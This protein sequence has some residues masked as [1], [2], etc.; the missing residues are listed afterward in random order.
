M[1]ARVRFLTGNRTGITALAALAGVL[2]ASAAPT[3]AAA[4]GVD[5]RTAHHGEPA[6]VPSTEDGLPTVSR[7]VLHYVVPPIFLVRDDGRSVMLPEELGDGRPVVLNFI[8]TTCTSL[9]PLASHVLSEVQRGLG[10]KRDSVHLVSISVDPEEDTPGRLKEYARRFGAGPSWH[11]YTGT[12][13]ASLAAQRAFDAYRGDKMSHTPLTLVR[14]TPAGPWVRFDGFATA[15]M[16][17][18]ELS[19]ARPVEDGL[20]HDREANVSS[21]ETPASATTGSAAR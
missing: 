11:H 5:P 21:G 4:E 13:A 14:S 2:A 20:A 19:V 17:L 18:K 7:S 9:C 3:S 8:Y 12:V 15:E 1:S 16:I 6:A 10:P